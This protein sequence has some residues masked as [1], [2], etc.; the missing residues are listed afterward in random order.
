MSQKEY[1]RIKRAKCLADGTCHRCGKPAI[2]GRAICTM[3]AEKSVAN[4]TRWAASRVAAAVCKRCGGPKDSEH[5]NCES[6]RVLVKNEAF[7]Y[8]Q[9]ENGKTKRKAARQKNGWKRKTPE[10][11]Q[12]NASYARKRRHEDPNFKIASALRNRLFKAVRGRHKSGSAVRDMG[13]TI[14]KFRLYI[15]SKFS[16]GMSWGNHGAWHLDH[17][18]PLASFDLTDEKQFLK[19][20]HY[21]NIQPLWAREN[22]LKS[23]TMPEEMQSAAI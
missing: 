11:L 17:I 10:G 21:S 4:A 1:L 6:C 22:L 19:A 2:Q 23:D 13:C 20:C 18:I 8:N 7:E 16:D 3:C 14:D 15:E 12:K 5:L 9:T